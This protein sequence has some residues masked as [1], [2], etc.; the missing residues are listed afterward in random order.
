LKIRSD[1]K[2]VEQLANGIRSIQGRAFHSNGDLFFAD[3]K[4]GGN[5]SEELDVLEIGAF[6]GHNPKKVFKGRTD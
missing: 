4:G 1:G 3:N 2:K 5:S 6:Y